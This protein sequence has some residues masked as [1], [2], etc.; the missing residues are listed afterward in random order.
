PRASFPSATV[1]AVTA[2]CRSKPSRP[3]R[4]RSSSPPATTASSRSS[5]RSSVGQNGRRSRR[6]PPMPHAWRTSPRCWRRS[7]GCSRRRARRRRLAPALSP[8][9]ITR[10]FLV[11]VIWGLA[12]VA[13]R[14]GLDDLSP[15]QLA[16]A[17]FVIAAVPALVLARPA[18]PW[19]ML[20]A[21][22]LTLFAGQF[23]LQ[24]FVIAGGMPAGLL[25][26]VVAPQL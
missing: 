9:D 11:V 7:P 25:S 13:T 21:V 16:A 14:I 4:V 12:F 23:L 20:I 8:R 10:A 19:T 18:V 15:A 17:R 3:R 6:T 1:R 22:G 24:F 2:S 26:T 5:R